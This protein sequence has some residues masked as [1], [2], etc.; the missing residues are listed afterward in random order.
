MTMERPG[1]WMPVG[2][3]RATLVGSI[4]PLASRQMHIGDALGLVLTEPVIAPVSVPRFAASAMDGYAL[5]SHDTSR[6][7]VTLSVVGDAR[8]G[9]PAH[10]TVAP[11]QAVAIATGAALPNGADAVCPVESTQ[12][13]G[14]QVVIEQTC[15]PGRFVRPIGDDIAAGSTVFEAGTRIRPAHIGVLASLGISE[16]CVT[17]RA[18]V[19]VLATGDEL[20]DDERALGPG[21]ILDANRPALL[22]AC[23]AAGFATV[24]LGIVGDDPGALRNALIDAAARCDV[25]L[26]SG[27]VSVGVA[28]HLKDVL[29]EMSPDTRTWW[30]VRIKPGKPF[31]YALVGDARVPVLCLP[32]NPVSALV[33]FEILARP[34]ID[35]RAG[36]ITGVP[37][38]AG[39]QAVA[40][41]DFFREPDGK[42]H[43]VRAVVQKGGDGTLVARP[44]GPQGS[45]Q[46]HVLAQANALAVVDDGDGVKAGDK[47]SFLR[48]AGGEAAHRES[49]P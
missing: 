31:G 49:T 8:A 17:P 5:R 46:L 36:L 30:E 35:K 25:V 29:G 1:K 37:E 18:R 9:V 33:V 15:E 20:V 10:V 16:V 32:G 14:D 3:A 47:V 43:F 19:G 24:D 13:H 38:L 45:H 4:D 21:R 28:D 39:E 27:G 41:D 22:A 2:D 42:I 26:T 48:L 44:A 40:G 12:L 23:Q 34:A 11:G 6:A 7:P